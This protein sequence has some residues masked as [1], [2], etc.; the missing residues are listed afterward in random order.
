MSG[1]LLHRKLHCNV[2]RHNAQQSSYLLLIHRDRWM[3]SKQSRRVAGYSN[4][5]LPIPSLI[6]SQYSTVCVSSQAHFGI[7]Y[8]PFYCVKKIYG[9][10]TD[11][12]A[13]CCKKH[14]NRNRY[15]KILPPDCLKKCAQRNHPIRGQNLLRLTYS[16]NRSPLI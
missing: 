2:I 15:K 11:Q 1:V 8:L 6:S 7:H 12:A 4:Y 13:D 10:G 16:S 14:V 5:R 3:I 9:M